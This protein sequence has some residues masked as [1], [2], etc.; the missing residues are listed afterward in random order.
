MDIDS[1]EYLNW[2]TKLNSIAD[3]YKSICSKLVDTVNGLADQRAYM[4]EDFDIYQGKVMD[5]SEKLKAMEE[6]LRNASQALDQ[7]RKN[8]EN[9]QNEL[10][11]SARK[12]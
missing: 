5:F 4:G 10:A 8:Y 7:Q 1:I 3:E 2:V 12:L 9:T 6:K 11:D